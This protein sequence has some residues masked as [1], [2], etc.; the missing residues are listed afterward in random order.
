MLLVVHAFN[1]TLQP[2]TVNTVAD[3][4]SH[5]ALVLFLSLVRAASGIQAG[6]GGHQLATHLFVRSLAGVSPTQH[7]PLATIR[8]L[9]LSVH[10]TLL[11]CH[12]SPEDHWWHA[13]PILCQHMLA[14]LGTWRT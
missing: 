1:F 14:D 10:K 6:L 8:P 2:G 5:S 13:R 9:S 3:A 12:A 4:D 7:W 11:E